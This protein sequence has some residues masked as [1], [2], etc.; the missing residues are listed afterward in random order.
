MLIYK[1]SN[2]NN[3]RN[4]RTI[5][6]SQ[7]H[8]IITIWHQLIHYWLVS[9]VQ[10]WVHHFTQK[11]KGS[12]LMVITECSGI[13]MEWVISGKD[14]KLIHQILCSQYITLIT[15]HFLFHTLGNLCI[16]IHIL[17][18]HFIKTPVRSLCNLWT[19]ICKLNKKVSMD[20]KNLSKVAYPLHM[21]I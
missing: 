8:R 6:C 11:C 19:A 14:L 18:A 10:V 3:N 17:I 16:L 1:K 21:T 9:I 12:S 2:N 7:Q 4:S 5:W 20:T 15:V 13:I